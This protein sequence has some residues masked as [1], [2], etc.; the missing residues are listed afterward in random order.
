MTFT[1]R[2][3]LSG[4]IKGQSRQADI[5]SELRQ[6]AAC[7]DREMVSQVIIDRHL[8]HINATTQVGLK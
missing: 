7:L 8:Y 3:G 5:G 2:I 4:L 6:V 1:A